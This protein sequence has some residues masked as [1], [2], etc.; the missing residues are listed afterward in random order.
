MVAEDDEKGEQTVTMGG[1]D[2][3]FPGFGF[4]RLG[5]SDCTP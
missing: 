4:F 1:V 5:A 3:F 2:H